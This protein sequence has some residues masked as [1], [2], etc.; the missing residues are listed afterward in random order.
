MQ[1][2]IAIFN[3]ERLHLITDTCRDPILCS[4]C[5]RQPSVFSRRH[6]TGEAQV[7]LRQREKLAGVTPEHA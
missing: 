2:M 6:H 4:S 5:A 1:Q 7:S 3:N